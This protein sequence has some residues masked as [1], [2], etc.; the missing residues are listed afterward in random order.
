MK[1]KIFCVATNKGIQ[2]FYVRLGGGENIFFLTK[3]TEKA[4]KCIFVMV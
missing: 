3:D 2:S 4:T 1:A